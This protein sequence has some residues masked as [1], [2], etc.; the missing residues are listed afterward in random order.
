MS[1]HRLLVRLGQKI[2]LR[3]KL[4]CR[5]IQRGL[6]RPIGLLGQSEPLALQLSGVLRLELPHLILVGSRCLLVR[7]G[8]AI[9]LRFEL[10]CRSVQCRLLLRFGLLG[11]S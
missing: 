2:T 8:H 10:V 6:L 4:S 5:V 7:L 11:Q 9:V 1:G 3:L